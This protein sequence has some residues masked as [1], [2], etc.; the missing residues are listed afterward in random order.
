MRE[1]L[2][3]AAPFDAELSG[4][5]EPPMSELDARL[6]AVADSGIRER[7]TLD[8]TVPP[9]LV[10][11]ERITGLE[12]TYLTRIN[13]ETEVQEVIFSRNV[14]DL[15]I[16]E[17]LSVDWE[18]TLCRRVLMG[19]PAVTDN[20]PADYPDS[21][22]A[23]ALGLQTFAS[24]AVVSP[25]GSVW[26]TLC[27]VSARPQ[28]ID[29]G[30]RHVLA[31]FARLIADYIFGTLERSTGAPLVRVVIADDSAVARALLGKVLTPERGF[32]VV[33]EASD[34]AEAV[35]V[36]EREQ[37]DVVTLDLEMPGVDGRQAL[38]LLR[39][40]DP[41]QAAVIFSAHVEDDIVD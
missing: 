32:V 38:A 29:D 31:L 10:E 2:A 1:L 8:T 30:V 9:L 13:W 23:R 36:A 27:G 41:G 6:M 25:D 17:G 14:G 33:G 11:L 21:E 4:V 22:A 7:G 24:A 35:T 37:P 34:G 26:G 16:P 12:S 3:F 15:D 40:G 19:G 18:D 20:V 5:G 39:S 28:P